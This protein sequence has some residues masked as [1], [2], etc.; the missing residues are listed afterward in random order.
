MTDQRPLLEVND[1]VKH[2]AVRGGVLRRRVGTVHAVDGVA[3][4]RR[5]ETLGLVGES[6]CGKSTVARSVLRLVEP[7]SG[8]I[9]M[10]GT[11]IVGL[12]KAEMRPHR[13][14]MQIVFQDRS[15]RSTRA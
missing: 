8:A 4:R 6:G 13:R 12:S 10:N 9:K 5:G 14:S 7:S 2:Y 3:S 1:L 11:D 15:P